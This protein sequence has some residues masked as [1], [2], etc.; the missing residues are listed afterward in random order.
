MPINIES[1]QPFWKRYVRFLDRIDLISSAAAFVLAITANN[2]F[3]TLSEEVVIKTLNSIYNFKASKLQFF[4][5]EIDYGLILTK[6]IQLVVIS[7]FIFSTLI[8]LHYLFGWS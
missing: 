5:V 4:D 1:N 3:I 2:F 7:I 6:F 8:L